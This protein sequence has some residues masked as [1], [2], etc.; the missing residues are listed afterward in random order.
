MIRKTK[1]RQ[2]KII[3]KGKVDEAKKKQISSLIQDTFSIKVVWKASKDLE[4]DKQSEVRNVIPC[5]MKK[6]EKY[7]NQQNIQL[8][9][10]IQDLRQPYNLGHLKTIFD[11]NNLQDIQDYWITYLD[12]ESEKIIQNDKRITQKDNYIFGKNQLLQQSRL[13]QQNN[14]S[15]PLNNFLATTKQLTQLQS[16][17]HDNTQ[18][19]YYSI[20]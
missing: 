16:Q 4:K 1:Q 6:F 18:E 15:E 12:K 20:G 11:N 3:I 8:K 9:E 5:L 10:Q 19:Y 14:N 2:L 13:S 17:E 7:L